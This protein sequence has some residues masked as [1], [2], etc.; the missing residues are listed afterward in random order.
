MMSAAS[1]FSNIK[2]KINNDKNL[3]IHLTSTSQLELKY[4]DPGDTRLV[5]TAGWYS[6]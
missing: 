6:E 3:A 2:C 5:S 4:F 1:N